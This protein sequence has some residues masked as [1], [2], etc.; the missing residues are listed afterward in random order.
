MS[1][2]FIE[3]I[4]ITPKPRVKFDGKIELHRDERN[5]DSSVNN[6][7]GN[8]LKWPNIWSFYWRSAAWVVAFSIL[9]TLFIYAVMPMTELVLQIKPAILYGLLACSFLLI[10]SL[11]KGDKIRPIVSGQLRIESF[12]WYKMNHLMMVACGVIA[13]LNLMASFF[14]PPESWA[15]FELM[16]SLGVLAV[17]VA[18][19]AYVVILMKKIEQMEKLAQEYTWPGR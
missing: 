16:T 3:D 18:A 12:Q 11:Y 17:P 5:V 15:R 10:A 13:A 19:A 8:D 6:A 9:S 2:G 4:Q 14:L 1:E 7:E